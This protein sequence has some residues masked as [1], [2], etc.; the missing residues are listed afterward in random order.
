MSD[1]RTGPG[2]E[3]YPRT[4][5]DEWAPEDATPGRRIP[6]EP[7]P[8]ERLPGEPKEQGM[9]SAAPGRREGL[10]AD[11]WA[12]EDDHTG[13]PGAGA[14]RRATGGRAAGGREDVMRE[15]AAGGRAE[16]RTGSE[17]L[18][19]GTE[20]LAAGTASAG[21]AGAGSGT[22]GAGTGIRGSGDGDRYPA[23]PPGRG[24]GADESG[25]MP[26]DGL[27]AP[28]LGEVTGREAATTD[29][30]AAD[31]WP[32]APGT[33]GTGSRTV[34]ESDTAPS[35][36]GSPLLPLEETDE[37]DQRI[38]QL[39]AGFVDEPREAVAE[40][41]HALEEIATRFTEAVDRRRRTLR[42][43][44]EGTEDRGPGS[45]TD[46]EQLRLALRDYRE[47][48]GRLLHL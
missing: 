12:P 32:A 37:W 47:L 2:G 46:T 8:G 42:R 4:P 35:G 27:G 23:A 20:S 22:Q 18:R 1:S 33:P 44:W 25:T 17:G 7:R 36:T 26:D 39:V 5:D 28:Y 43:S 24:A 15:G 34:G 6:R 14:P 13:A 38:R 19:P 31:A 9:P 41:D 48:A 11:D 45:E 40:A 21:T 16:A 3:R 10:T 29:S 30:R